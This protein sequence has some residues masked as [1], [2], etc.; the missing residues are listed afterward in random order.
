MLMKGKPSV[1]LD[2]HVSMAMDYA[3]QLGAWRR[4]TCARIAS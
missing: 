2:V 3:C 1:Q 4:Q